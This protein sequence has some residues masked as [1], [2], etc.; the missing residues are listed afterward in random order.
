[1]DTKYYVANWKSNK[2]KGEA[3]E[4][5]SQLR[6]QIDSVDLSDKLIIIA[7][8]STLLDVCRDFVDKNSLPV[9]LAAQNVSSFPP[10]AYTG[11]LSAAQL[12][13]FVEYVIVGHSERI[14]Y[15][16][17]TDSD[18]ENKVRE[19]LQEG[20]KV[21]QCVQ[22]EDS[23]VHKGAEFIAYEPP[24]AIGSGNPDDPEHVKEVFAAISSQNEE[25][26]MLYGGSVKSENIGQ[27]SSIETMS[28]FLVGGASL[29]ADS[30]LSLLNG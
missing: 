21:I 22:S 1:M 3:V 9:K 30:F 19:A 4:F 24:S 12:K 28:G 23:K 15:M 11:E 6:D 18:I 13:E 17:E 27:Y 7:P 26:K 5:L 25:V 20:L 8:P 14:K 10:G 2:K 16:H 29:A